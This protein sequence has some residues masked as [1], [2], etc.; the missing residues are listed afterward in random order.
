M[1]NLNKLVPGTEFAKL[2]LEEIVQKA[3]PGPVFNNAAQVWNHTFYWDSLSPP[4]GGEPKVPLADADQEL[5]TFDSFV[6]EGF[7]KAAENSSAPAGCGW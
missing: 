5:G 2:S 6:G 1:A 3:P 4:G 7:T